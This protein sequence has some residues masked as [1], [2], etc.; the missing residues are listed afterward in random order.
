MCARDSGQHPHTMHSAQLHHCTA[1]CLRRQGPLPPGGPPPQNTTECVIPSAA[2]QI[3]PTLM[4]RHPPEPCSIG[5]EG[6]PPP[7]TV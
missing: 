1:K 3:Y 5:H 6:P 4:L 2:L 7:A